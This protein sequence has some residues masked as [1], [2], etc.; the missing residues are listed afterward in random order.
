MPFTHIVLESVQLC[1]ISSKR[2]L[3]RPLKNMSARV[4]ACQACNMLGEWRKLFYTDTGTD[5]GYRPAFHEVCVLA[6]VSGIDCTQN[7]Y[8]QNLVP[9]GSSNN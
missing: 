8:S 4:L 7:R 9:R 1:Q 5:Q 2:K 3:F 6:T